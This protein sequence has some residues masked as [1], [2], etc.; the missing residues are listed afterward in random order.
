MTTRPGECE[1]AEREVR[2]GAAPTAYPHGPCLC[3][4]SVA[5]LFVETVLVDDI[6]YK[7]LSVAAVVE[8]R[9]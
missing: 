6:G 8:Q 2:A 4:L 3:R 7:T 9:L 5:G 1:T